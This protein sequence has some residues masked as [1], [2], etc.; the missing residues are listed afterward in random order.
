[1]EGL[2]LKF[3]LRS[4]RTLNLLVE[5]RRT[6][7]RRAAALLPL[8][9]TRW[10]MESEFGRPTAFKCPRRPGADRQRDRRGVAKEW[11]GR[12]AATPCASSLSSLLPPWGHSGLPH[13]HARMVPRGP[14]RL[15][16]VSAACQQKGQARHRGRR[17]QTRW[18]RRDAGGCPVCLTRRR[19]GASL[20]PR[21]CSAVRRLGP[22]TATLTATQPATT[23]A[24]SNRRGREEETGARTAT[25][26]SR[27]ERHVVLL[28][29]LVLRPRLR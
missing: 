22:A 20:A 24:P 13:T 14:H 23:S 8:C 10:C 2:K 26:R 29:Q 17:W 25:R 6:A 7:H 5:F 19:R 15:S 21:A 12:I 11:T 3:A 9:A 28:P 16:G 4:G 1:V 18:C 27:A